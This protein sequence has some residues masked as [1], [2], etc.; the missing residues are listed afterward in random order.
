MKFAMGLASL[1]KRSLESSSPVVFSPFSLL[2]R[3]F[4]LC[5]IQQIAFLNKLCTELV[6]HQ[7]QNIV[8]FFCKFFS[9]QDTGHGRHNPVQKFRT[10]RTLHFC[11]LQFVDNG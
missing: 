2:A 9:V 11:R 3:H 1:V 6:V 5:L 10:D 7:P 8:W 4:Y